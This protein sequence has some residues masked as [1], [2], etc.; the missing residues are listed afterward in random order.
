[1]GTKKT[2]HRLL[3]CSPWSPRATEQF[4]QSKHLDFLEEKGDCEPGD[5]RWPCYLIVGGHVIN[6]SK[7]SLNILSPSQKGHKL[8][9][10]PGVNVLLVE[11]P[12]G[13]TTTISVVRNKDV[14]CWSINSRCLHMGVSLNGGIYPQTTHPKCWSFLVGKPM[15]LLGKP[16]I[17]GNP[18]M[19]VIKLT[20]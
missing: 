19:M 2:K 4:A 15:G 6:L 17:L 11:S 14:R 5:S 3:G 16:T 20:Q 1:M 7:R 18:H 9:E 10:L 8:A 12:P 13:F